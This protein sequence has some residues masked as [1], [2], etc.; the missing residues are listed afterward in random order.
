MFQNVLK[1]L[2]SEKPKIQADIEAGKRLQK[3]R[4]A[5]TFV[6]K[7]V[8]ELEGKWIDTNEKAKQKHDKLKVRFY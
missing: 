4:N 5:P 1:R 3:D 6:S 8:Q 7:S 2:E